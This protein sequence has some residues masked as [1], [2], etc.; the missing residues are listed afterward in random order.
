MTYSYL[1]ERTACARLRPLVSERKEKLTRLVHRPI[2]NSQPHT[3]DR[4]V[5]SPEEV[6]TA[7]N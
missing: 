4:V 5:G 2:V 3:S 6:T 1:R 7:F